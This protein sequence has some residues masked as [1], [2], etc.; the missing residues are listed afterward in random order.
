[1]RL[2][3]QLLMRLCDSEARA[4]PPAIEKMHKSD[5]MHKSDRGRFTDGLRRR[6]A[7]DTQYVARCRAD[8][9]QNPPSAVGFA[10]TAF[11]LAGDIPLFFAP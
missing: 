1:M 8:K 5:P 10:P 3:M 2:V 6:L 9:T 4:S 7:C 11:R